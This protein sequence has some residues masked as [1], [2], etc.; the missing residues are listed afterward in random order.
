MIIK[1][2]VP[3]STLKE[4]TGKNGD[5]YYKISLS[6]AYRNKDDEWVNNDVFL[7]KAAY[8]ALVSND[9]ETVYRFSG[10]SNMETV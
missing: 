10:K 5:V 4:F 6:K 9:K 2:S 1:V 7:T 3:E 8:D